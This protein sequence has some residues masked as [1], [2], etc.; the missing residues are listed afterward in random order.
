M[1]E[2]KAA[3]VKIAPVEKWCPYYLRIGV[4]R[5]LA[6]GR[7]VPVLTESCAVDPA[8]LN[9]NGH[10]PGSRWWKLTD[11]FVASHGRPHGNCWLCEH[12]LEMD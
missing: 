6:P 9:L 3:Q 12:V 7:M 8:S 4:G 11:E 5:Y 1:N 10:E 2:E